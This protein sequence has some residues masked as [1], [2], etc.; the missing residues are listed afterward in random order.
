M[1]RIAQ[2][3]EPVDPGLFKHAG[4]LKTRL[5]AVIVVLACMVGVIAAA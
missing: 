4:A 1:Q 3:L 5:T 2:D